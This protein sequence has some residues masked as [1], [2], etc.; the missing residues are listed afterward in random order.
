PAKD[1]A[2]FQKAKDHVA[3]DGFGNVG[4]ALQFAE[5]LA[6]DSGVIALR[7][8]IAG[9]LGICSGSLCFEDVLPIGDDLCQ[10]LGWLRLVHGY[11][12]SPMLRGGVGCSDRIAGWIVGASP[13][14]MPMFG[15]RGLLD[16]TC[17]G[18]WRPVIASIRNETT[19]RGRV[20]P[21]P[22]HRWAHQSITM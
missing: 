22:A 21:S 8:L 14:S 11:F 15:A 18:R 19:G 12:S 10:L 4:L 16:S 17:A 20:F 7:Q 3:R 9:Q 13:R 2:T 1:A 6:T 5:Q